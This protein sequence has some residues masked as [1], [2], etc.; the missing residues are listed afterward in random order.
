M[1]CA[2]PPVDQAASQLGWHPG[3]FLPRREDAGVRVRGAPPPRAVFHRGL[4]FMADE[5]SPVVAPWPGTIVAKGYQRRGFMPSDDGLGHYVVINHGA[6][7]PRIASGEPVA[8]M[9]SQLREASPRNVGDTVAQGDLLGYVGRSGLLEWRADRP[10]LYFQALRTT[11]FGEPVTDWEQTAG[12]HFDVQRD[13]FRPLGLETEGVQDPGTPF[14]PWE[15]VPPWGGRLVQ[16]SACAAGVAGLAGLGAVNPQTIRDRYTRY[17][18][19]QLTRTTPYMPAIRT[20]A[21]A[22]SGTGGGLILGLAVV[23]GAWWL[24]RR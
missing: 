20:E 24:L 19:T 7:G 17:G 13:F 1:P 3:V 18:S 21:A 16:R 15:Q 6:L 5:G 14:G 22:S 12:N 11:R 2:I 4:D 8:T 10:L 9:Y 23:A